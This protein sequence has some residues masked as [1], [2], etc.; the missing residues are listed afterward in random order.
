VWDVA[1]DGTPCLLR[2]DHFAQVDGHPVD[3]ANDYLRPFAD[4]YAR[5]IRAAQT[6]RYWHTGGWEV[7]R[8]R[9]KRLPSSV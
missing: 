4:R 8:I 9:V 2:P 3:F 5:E 6:L 1:A 7:H